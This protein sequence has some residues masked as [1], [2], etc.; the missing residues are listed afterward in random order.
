VTV[1]AS[2]NTLTAAMDNSMCKDRTASY[3]RYY[4]TGAVLIS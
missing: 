3:K 4:L 1:A 2:Q